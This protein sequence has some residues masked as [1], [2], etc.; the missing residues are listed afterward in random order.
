MIFFHDI[1]F[2]ENYFQIQRDKL[3]N[4]ERQIE[5]DRARAI[6][7]VAITYNATLECTSYTKE[8]LYFTLSFVDAK[9][10]DE[11]IHNV[12]KMVRSSIMK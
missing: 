8:K 4:K 1:S 11:F 3:T 5:F 10:A 12:D 9:Q 6:L 2:A 7:K